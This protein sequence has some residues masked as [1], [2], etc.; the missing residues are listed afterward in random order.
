MTGWQ[1]LAI[2]CNRD[3]SHV[4]AVKKINHVNQYVK[5]TPSFL[6]GIGLK[7]AYLITMFKM[8]KEVMLLKQQV[9]DS[10]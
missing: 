9:V 2:S 6:G 7:F 5:W 1:I 4:F 8:N 10:R 3:W